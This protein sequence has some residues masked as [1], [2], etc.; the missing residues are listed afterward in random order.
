MNILVV[1]NGFDLAHGL[2]TKYSDFLGFIDYFNIFRSE[3]NIDIER[4]KEADNFK[5][6]NKNVQKYLLNEKT[7]D[8]DNELMNELEQIASENI[9]IKHLI[10]CKR[11]N[12]LKGENWIDFEYE[13]SEIIK[14]LDYFERKKIKELNELKNYQASCVKKAR[15]FI[16]ENSKVLNIY[17]KNN[18]I[19]F[20]NMTF[21]EENYFSDKKMVINIL[22]DEL[23]NLIRALEIYLGDIVGSIPVNNR[24]K[25]IEDI[26]RNESIN[27]VISFNY[28]NTFEKLYVNENEEVKYDYIHGTLD[29][30]R[31]NTEN[32]MVL[33]IDEYLTGNEK[34]ERLDFIKFKKYFQRIYKKTGCEYKKWLEIDGFIDSENNYGI[35][36]TIYIW[37]FS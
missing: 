26:Q 14:G 22:N 27:K 12:L 10:W 3:E 31:D 18:N 16:N 25:D 30:S 2:P 4:I 13:I 5:K 23:N 19:T 21:I 1:G 34:N 15:K 7:F 24:L 28:T 17:S 35:A 33:G 11:E 6:L 37:T 36:N 32:N 8:Q 29:I 20:V 9:W